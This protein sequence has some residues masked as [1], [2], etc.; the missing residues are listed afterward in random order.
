MIIGKATAIG[1]AVVLFLIGLET[2]WLDKGSG[3]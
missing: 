1:L 2:A 3:K